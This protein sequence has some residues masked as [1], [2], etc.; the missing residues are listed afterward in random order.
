MMPAK[1]R[2]LLPPIK[3]FYNISGV[4]PLYKAYCKLLERGVS[5]PAL[6]DEERKR[7]QDVLH[8]IIFG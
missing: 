4:G 2:Y 8:P 7:M 3:S 5:A 1:I 6:T